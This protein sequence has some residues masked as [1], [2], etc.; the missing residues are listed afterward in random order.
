MKEL[1]LR[2]KGIVLHPLTACALYMFDSF[3]DVTQDDSSLSTSGLFAGAEEA[4]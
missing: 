1:T 4:L 2:L 3:S